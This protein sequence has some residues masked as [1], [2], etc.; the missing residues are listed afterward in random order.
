VSVTVRKVDRVSI[1]VRSL[2]RARAFFERHFGAE[3]G[4]V[5]DVA[6]DG[7]RYVPFTIGG[8][9]LELLEPYEAK[10]PIARFLDRRGEGLYQLSLTVDDVPAAAAALR[11]EGLS[12]MGPRTYDEDVVLEGCRWTEA[13]VHPKDAHGVLI[14]LGQ[15]TPVVADPT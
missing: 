10:S 12:V 6:V 2:E 11:E 15:R 4:P 13:F 7:Y 14:F 5:E 3:F 8:F 1:A 9:T